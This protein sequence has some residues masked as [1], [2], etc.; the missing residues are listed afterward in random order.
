MSYTQYNHVDKSGLG[1]WS[2]SKM[3]KLMYLYVFFN[4]NITDI[5]SQG[6]CDICGRTS[7]DEKLAPLTHVCVKFPQ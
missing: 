2:E 5:C 6:F 1:G 3:F 4:T 7:S